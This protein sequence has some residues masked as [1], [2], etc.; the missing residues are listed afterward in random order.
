MADPVDRLTYTLVNGDTVDR[1]VPAGTGKTQIEE[2][3][4]EDWMRIDDTTVIRTEHI[5]SIKLKE[6]L[7]EH[8]A[9][10]Y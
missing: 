3:I 9:A 2:G 6:S 7:R 5:V 4:G 10:G 1:E 8:G